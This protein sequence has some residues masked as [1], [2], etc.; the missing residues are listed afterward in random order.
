MSRSVPTGHTKGLLPDPGP[1]NTTLESPGW[2]ERLGSVKNPN[3]SDL[4]IVCTG[5]RFEA[6]DVLG[7]PVSGG[8]LPD[9]T[10]SHLSRPGHRGESGV[11]LLLWCLP[12]R[13]AIMTEIGY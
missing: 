3:R 12:R 8:Y 10:A 1:S 5:L 2:G 9:G 11:S 4:N 7:G 13:T 6:T